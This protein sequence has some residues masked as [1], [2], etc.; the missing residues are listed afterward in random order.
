MLNRNFSIGQTVMVTQYTYTEIKSGRKSQYNKGDT[1]VIQSISEDVLCDNDYNFVHM[2]DVIIVEDKNTEG[3]NL[4]MDVIVNTGMEF[5][6]SN[7]KCQYGT[8]TLLGINMKIV[9][10]DKD[11]FQLSAQQSNIDIDYCRAIG[12]KTVNKEHLYTAVLE[13]EERVLTTNEIYY[14]KQLVEC[15]KAKE[16]LG[17][18]NHVNI[19]SYLMGW[20]KYKFMQSGV[21]YGDSAWVTFCDESFN[22]PIEIGIIELAQSNSQIKHVMEKFD[23]SSK[24]KFKFC[25]SDYYIHNIL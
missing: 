22:E 10:S 19:I 16:N 13:F 25:N 11:S 4:L 18:E 17:K 3:H 21:G 2:N 7:H 1:F 20:S 9:Q 12:T 23:L 6:L 24:V 14:K 8:I 15:K 5:I